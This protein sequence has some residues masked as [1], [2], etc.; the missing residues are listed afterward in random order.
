M[1]RA[2]NIPSQSRPD[3]AAA[4]FQLV[5]TCFTYERLAFQRLLSV[6]FEAP[7]AFSKIF[8]S[9]H[10]AAP[11]LKRENYTENSRQNRPQYVRHRAAPG[12][13]RERLTGNSWPWNSGCVRSDCERI[14]ELLSILPKNQGAKARRRLLAEGELRRRTVRFPQRRSRMLRSSYIL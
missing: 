8:P 6:C 13:R 5:F 3:R 1:Q 7:Q 14:L 12:L 11:G 9:R 10:H 4:L 2:S